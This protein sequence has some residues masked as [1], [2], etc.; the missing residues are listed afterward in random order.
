MGIAWA[1]RDDVK[2]NAL[3][4]GIDRLEDEASNGCRLCA[5]A[6]VRG[7]VVNDHKINITIDPYAR[8]LPG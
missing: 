5:G 6:F 4:P 2:G 1:S 7:K 8:G 3:V